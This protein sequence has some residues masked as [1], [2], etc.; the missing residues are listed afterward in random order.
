MDGFFKKE[1]IKHRR[2]K[3]FTPKTNGM[4]E[5]AN[6]IINRDTILKEQYA[7]KGRNEYTSYAISYIL[8]ALQKIWK[9][10]NGILSANTF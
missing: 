6:G 2:T 7:N 9:W 4:V 1:N 3:P 8:F 10:K 5:R